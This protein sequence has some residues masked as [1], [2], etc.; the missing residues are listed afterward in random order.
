MMGRMERMAV[1]RQNR[2]PALAAAMLRSTLRGWTAGRVGDDCFL[3]CHNSIFPHHQRWQQ[4]CRG[5][6][7]AIGLQ[8]GAGSSAAEEHIAQLD[9]RTAFLYTTNASSSNAEEHTL[10]GWVAGRVGAVCFEHVALLRGHLVWAAAVLRSTHCVAG[11]QERWVRLG[12]RIFQPLR[13]VLVLSTMVLRHTCVHSGTAG[14][15]GVASC[16]I[17]WEDV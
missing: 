6:H 13:G 15:V 7:C 3:K 2:P 4:R 9:C 11:P 1:M 8:E 10:R 16:S 14:I 17:P 12:A 5:A